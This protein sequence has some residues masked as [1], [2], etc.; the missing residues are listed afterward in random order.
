MLLQNSNK[1]SPCDYGNEPDK[2]H[3]K[4]QIICQWLNDNPNINACTDYENLSFF[5]RSCKYDIERTKK[6]I[7]W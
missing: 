4:V 1:I 2:V 6:K 7:K 5:L 3:Q